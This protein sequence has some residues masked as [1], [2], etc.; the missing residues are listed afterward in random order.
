MLIV[1]KALNGDEIGMVESANYADSGFEFCAL[2]RTTVFDQPAE[3]GFEIRIGSLV[4]W[5]KL[6]NIH[7][8]LAHNRL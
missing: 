6:P 5:V 1:E 8:K 4:E 7:Y 3:A 2:L